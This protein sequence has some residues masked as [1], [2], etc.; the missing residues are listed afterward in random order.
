M[1]ISTIALFSLV[2]LIFWARLTPA[3][4]HSVMRIAENNNEF[5]NISISDVLSKIR[6]HEYE[7][8]P[9]ESSYYV[10]SIAP[11]VSQTKDFPGSN[12]VCVITWN[13]HKMGEKYIFYLSKDDI[14]QKFI[15]VISW[16]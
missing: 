3:S 2:L 16:D 7:S 6:H 1:I 15:P 13:T 5:V 4:Y 11:I 9:I 14:V 12:K 10:N 8:Y